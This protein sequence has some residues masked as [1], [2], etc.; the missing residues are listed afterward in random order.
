MYKQLIP[1]ISI[2]RGDEDFDI[3]D[4]ELNDEFDV[5][6]NDDDDDY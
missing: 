4:Y 5:Y 2:D 1:I 6:D 3:E